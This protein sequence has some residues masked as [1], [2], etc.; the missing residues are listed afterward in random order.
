MSSYVINNQVRPFN[1]GTDAI[2]RMR[3]SLGQSVIDADFEYGLQST[4]WQNYQE[5]RK[6]PSFYEIPGTDFVVTNV[7]S[8]GQAT[9]VI[10]VTTSSTLPT[11]GSVIVISGLI[12]SARTADRAEGFFLVTGT[13][14]GTFTYFAKGQVVSGSIFTNYTVLRKGGVFTNGNAKIQVSTVVQSTSPDKVLVT[15]TTVHGL[16]AGTPICG[17]GWSGAGAI[18]NFF[19]ETTP[20]T[21]QFT[22]TPVNSGVSATLTGGIIYVQPYSYTVHRPFDGG[23]LISPAQPANG[24]SVVRQSK[25]V[26]RYQSGKGFLWSS[27][28]L[29]C[30]N[31]DITS[32]TAA[33]TAVTSIITITTAISHGAPQIGAS[34]EIRGVVTSGYNGV[35]AIAS[36]VDHLTVTVVATQTLGSITGVLGTQ[37]RFIM[38]NWHGASVRAGP[39][40]DQ[41]GLFWEY[42]GQTLWVVKRSSTFQIAGTCLVS[43]NGQTLTNDASNTSNPT[44]FTQQ[45]KVGDRFT[46]RG[47]THTVTSIINDSTLTFNPPYR[48]VAAI[49]VGANVCRINE[50]RVPQSQFNRDTIDGFGPS[51]YNVDLTKM[52]MIGLQYTW[53]GAGFVDFMIRGIDG[54]WVFVHR[55][56][57][58]NVNDEAYMRTGNMPVRYELINECASAISTLQVQLG[59]ADTTMTLNDT[60]TYWPNTGTVLIDNEFIYYGAKTGNIL[61]SL[62]RGYVLNYNINDVP[63]SFRA[64]TADG[65]GTTHLLGASVNLI[66]CT[67]TPSLTH[68]GSAFIMDGQFDQDRGY[69]FN[70]QHNQST[71]ITAGTTQPL[72]F[73]RLSPSVSNGVIGDIGVR[74]LLNRA[75][76][77]LQKLTV[78]PFGSGCVLNIQ[79][80]LNPLG[81]TGSSF[82]WNSINSQG[83]QPSFG[84][85]ATMSGVSGTWTVGSGERIFSMIANVAAG[86]SELDLSQLKE[87]SNTVPGG[88]QMF[89]DGPDTLMII[90]TPYYTNL[91][92]AL[93]NL[94]WSEAQA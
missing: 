20:A 61:Q 23:C 29:F 21:N 15:T 77:L 59:A 62:S 7:T 56:V 70:Y 52:Q 31:N 30:P 36:V 4:K 8:D 69:F 19:I 82:T 50:T 17:T 11:V 43:V 10:T 64:G 45:F 5:V 57:N 42:D 58:N 16:I 34:I 14:S 3:V 13:G 87:L 25:K 6:T 47:M 44:R 46:L 54:N 38:R 78:A 37:P 22:F 27:G 60:T 12:N 26:F 55:F 91:T 48:G 65:T 51:K 84:Q 53:Y 9:S 75:Q 67:C 93:I 66:S 2:E 71:S 33:G 18:G 49:T 63:K 74:D 72:F 83:G 80:V 41:N 40:D 92:T 90:A 28:T 76:I 1:F 89:P 73:L 32:V 35:Y 94:Y 24:S 81:F 79:G 86:Q 88:N 85:Y 68:W 39:F